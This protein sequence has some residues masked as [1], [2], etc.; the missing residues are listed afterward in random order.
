[1]RRKAPL[2]SG[3][4]EPA[5][6]RTPI[7]FHPLCDEMKIWSAA[8]AAE[9]SDWPD[10]TARSFFGFTALYRGTKMFAA[11]PRTRALWTPSSIGFKIEGAGPD[12]RQRL[13]SD[14]RIQSTGKQNTRWFAFEL[15]SGQDLH[16][17]LEWLGAAYQAAGKKRKPK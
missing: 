9:V 12:L 4:R 14:P 2:T 11:L 1:M 8:L 16:D 6:A 7:E 13:E 5:P 17:S 3:Q 10:C 15:S